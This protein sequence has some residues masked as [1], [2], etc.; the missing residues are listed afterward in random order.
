MF[1]QCQQSLPQ[2]K[3]GEVVENL[4]QFSTDEAAE[5]SLK[6]GWTIDD[7]KTPENLGIAW[8]R[9]VEGV[10]KDKIHH[11]QRGSNR[12]LGKNCP[13]VSGALQSIVGDSQD[14][15][16]NTFTCGTWLRSIEYGLLW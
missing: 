11:S 3:M 10:L 8:E 7:K 15:P 13:R 12:G 6:V 2:T 1:L 5:M 9:T 4:D 14:N 16:L